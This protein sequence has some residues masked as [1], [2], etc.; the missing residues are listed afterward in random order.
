MRH[1]KVLICCIC[2]STP[3]VTYDEHTQTTKV[4][5]E[6]ALVKGTKAQLRMTFT[7]QLNDKMAG[8][9]RSTYK[10]A[11]GSEGI[12]VRITGE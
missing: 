1:S 11:D 6:K 4:A 8:F 7:G 2:S 3:A 10:N 5:F 12:L 9:Y